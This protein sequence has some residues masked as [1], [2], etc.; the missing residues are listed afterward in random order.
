[1][2]CMT[3]K[4]TSKPLAVEK[5]VRINLTDE[6]WR[7]LRVEAAEQDIGVSTLIGSLLMT[8]VVKQKHR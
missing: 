1:M 4:A 2:L 8:H 6:D 5:M 7:A 3:T